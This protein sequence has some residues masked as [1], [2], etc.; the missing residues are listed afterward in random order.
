RRTRQ[1]G[2][3]PEAAGDRRCALP[4]LRHL[5]EPD[6]DRRHRHED[7]LTSRSHL[8]RDG[9]PATWRRVVGAP[10]RSKWEGGAGGD[11]PACAASTSSTESPYRSSFFRSTPLTWPSSLLV[12]GLTSTMP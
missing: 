5:H 9:A 7:R 1:P 4:R 10:S 12:L 2:G 8:L 6:P 11:Q 3:L